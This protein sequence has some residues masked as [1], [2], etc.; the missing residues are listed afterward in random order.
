MA[1]RLGPL[2]ADAGITEVCIQ[3]DVSRTPGAE[4]TPTVVR[5]SQQPG[6]G[7]RLQT[8]DP[9]TEPLGALSSYDEKVLRARRRGQVYPYELF[10]LVA[11]SRGTAVELDLDETGTLVEVDRPH[12]QNSAGIIV[13]DVTTP[14][15]VHPEGVRRIVLFGDP[16]KSLGSISRDEADRIVAGIDRAESLGVP[17]DWF[18]LS[19]GAR[20]SM[21]SGTENLD[22]VAHAL[23]RIV[24]FTQ[25]GGEINVIV[26]G[27]NVGAQPY[28]KAEATMLMHTRG[29]LVM[30]PD[31]AMV[32]TGKQSLDFS[33]GVSAEDNFGIGGHDRIMG[34]N[35]QA[36]YWAASL[37]EAQQVLMRH[38]ERSYVAPGEQRPRDIPTADD[39]HRDVGTAPHALEGSD[40]DTVGEIF[41]A[42]KNAERKKPF[43]I[44]T[45]MRAVADLDHE[46]LERWAAMA[47][48]D[49]A[50]VFDTTIDA[51][52]ITLIGIESKPTPR[53]G[54][55]PADG[56]DSFSGGTLFPRSS[57]KVAHAINAASGN[58][59]VVVLAN[60]SCPVSRLAGVH[61][62]P[63]AGVRR[64]DRPG[65]RE[66][67]RA[68]HLHRHQP[69]P[70]R[71]LC[72]VLQVAER[73]DDGARPGGLV[74]V[75]D[76]WRAGRCRRLRP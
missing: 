32:L 63:A 54:F 4:P 64:R 22:A 30:T 6:F 65:H 28:W 23:R 71:R 45:V 55:L 24:G 9:A 58:R 60:L 36:Q 13:A 70:R 34:L 48:A 25:D 42:Q 27:I 52:P 31:S 18:T 12:G 61:A 67:R 26:A 57:K 69:L 76:R 75:G 17:V 59:P 3:G 8:I 16:L 51:M 11:S 72:R 50:V 7:V 39:D 15:A 5:F 2:T 44:R 56:P 49:P 1:P 62:Q 33:G 21:T 40:F 35:G 41:S 74:C 20:I 14:T 47:D 46:P 43:D 38:Y 68:D 19:S 73:P 66:L 53:A 10:G 29:I 37:A